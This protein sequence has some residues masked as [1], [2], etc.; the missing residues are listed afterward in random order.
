[1]EQPPNVSERLAAIR[2]TFPNARN[3]EVKSPRTREYN[4]IAYAMGEE[5]RNWWPN[6]HGAGYW[7]PGTMA[8][9]IPFPDQTISFPKRLAARSIHG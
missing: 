3:L 2:K 9:L 7:P 1:M 6:G 8:E 5:T 4:C